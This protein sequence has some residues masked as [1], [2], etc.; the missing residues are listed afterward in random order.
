M[1]L[2][3][4][5]ILGVGLLGGSI[6]LAVRERIQGCRVVG[7]GHRAQ[8]LRDALQVGALDEAYEAPGEAVRGADLV[9][10][11]TPVG[12]IPSLLEQI[13]GDLA[14]G[15]IVT[16]V[17][18]TK[19]SIVAAAE[20]ALPRGVHFVGSHPMAGSEKRGV[21][22]ARADLFERAVCITTPTERTS[23]SALGK[24]ESFWQVLGMRTTRLSPDEHD[25][26][27]ADVSHLPHIVAAALV[28]MQEDA[29][30][31]LCGKGFVDVTRIAGGDAGLWRDILLDNRDNVR[32]SITRLGEEMKRLETL[33]ETGQSDA[34][35]KWLRDA[36]ERR[37]HMLERKQPDE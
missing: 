24:V 15:A 23:E 13:A 4:V 34:L 26:L 8:T 10:V 37:Q 25:R 9:I 17:G 14:Q 36:A 19:R 16:D 20:K 11:C 21:Q 35:A 31:N 12:L 33:L 28:A 22:F 6:G 7:Y 1:Q 29:A 30:F 18:S 2:R 32:R 5:S 27:L 3:R